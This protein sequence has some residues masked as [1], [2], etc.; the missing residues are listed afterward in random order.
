MY[1]NIL[2]KIPLKNYRCRRVFNN[3]HNLP[4]SVIIIGIGIPAVLKLLLV[5]IY[6][7]KYLFFIVDIVIIKLTRISYE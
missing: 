7:F 4:N 5:P 1:Y 2:Y 3:T 6:L